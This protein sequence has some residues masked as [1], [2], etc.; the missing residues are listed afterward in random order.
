M[1]LLCFKPFRIQNAPP[2]PRP[3]QMVHAGSRDTPTDP[4][5]AGRKGQGS[6]DTP[7]APAINEERTLMFFFSALFVCALNHVHV[8]MHGFRHSRLVLCL[9]S[10]DFSTTTACQNGRPHLRFWQPWAYV[11]PLVSMHLTQITACWAI[12]HIQLRWGAA[13][14]QSH[15]LLTRLSPN[16]SCDCTECA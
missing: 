13:H 2:P 15:A 7:E 1:Q 14:P 8:A 4:R 9:S 6:E 11:C 10:I 12:C 16:C 3:D 5:R